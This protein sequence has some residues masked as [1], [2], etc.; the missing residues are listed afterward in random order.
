MSS[1]GILLIFALAVVVSAHAE[2]LGGAGT[3]L[4][5]SIAG[6]IVGRFGTENNGSDV[7]KDYSPANK[8]APREGEALFYAPIDHLFDGLLNLAAHEEK[9]EFKF[10]IHELYIST[11]KLI[12]RS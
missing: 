9:G 1:K 10:E 2:T 12:P 8:L 6:D 3:G 11:S 7:A 5:A 4:Q